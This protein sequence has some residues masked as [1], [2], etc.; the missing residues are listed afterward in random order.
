MTALPK[1]G[2]VVALASLSLAGTLATGLVVVR[3]AAHMRE[4]AWSRITIQSAGLRRREDEILAAIERGTC[5]R[6][7]AARRPSNATRT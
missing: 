4:D 1:L 7:G 5:T 2:P 3:L 6:C